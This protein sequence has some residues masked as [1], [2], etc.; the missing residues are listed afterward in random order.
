MWRLPA[1]THY[2]Y[3][4]QSWSEKA[5]KSLRLCDSAISLKSGPH[6]HLPLPCK[7]N[8]RYDWVSK[9]VQSHHQPVSLVPWHPLHQETAFRWPLLESSDTS[10]VSISDAT[11][12]MVSWHQHGVTFK[13]CIDVEGHL[14]MSTF[15]SFGSSRF[16]PFWAPELRKSFT[17]HFSSHESQNFNWGLEVQIESFIS[18]FA[19]RVGG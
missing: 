6:S 10:T 18:K 1:I 13:E 14:E 12:M 5:L 8:L 7:S 17:F 4:T 9:R 15:L 16:I 3:H 11:E 19:A 2:H